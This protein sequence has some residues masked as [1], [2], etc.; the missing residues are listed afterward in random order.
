MDACRT[1]VGKPVAYNVCTVVTAILYAGKERGHNGGKRDIGKLPVIPT[2]ES[3]E[4]AHNWSNKLSR[5]ENRDVMVM[6]LAMRYNH[7][8]QLAESTQ[9]ESVIRTKPKGLGYDV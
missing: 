4:T 3:R 9:L 8:Y 7:L 5:R 6:D 1:A 2:G